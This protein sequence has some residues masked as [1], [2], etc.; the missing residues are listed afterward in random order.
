M[1]DPLGLL[2]VR[3]PHPTLLLQYPL[4]LCPSKVAADRGR[5]HRCPLAYWLD[6]SAPGPVPSSYLAMGRRLYLIL[7]V[8]DV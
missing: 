8:V 1:P 6:P 2:G 4:C 7:C 5:V 3:L